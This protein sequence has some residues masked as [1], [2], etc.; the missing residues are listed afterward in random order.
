MK[1]FV[2][3]KKQKKSALGAGGRK[4]ESYYPDN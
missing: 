4:F 1:I 2:K 3:Q